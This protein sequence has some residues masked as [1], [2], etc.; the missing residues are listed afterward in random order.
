MSCAQPSVYSYADTVVTPTTLSIT[1]KNDTRRDG[2]R[3]RDRC[4]V[5]AACG[6]TLS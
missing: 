3:S 1:L 4:A 2:D 6:R 5:P